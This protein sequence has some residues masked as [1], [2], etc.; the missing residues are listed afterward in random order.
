MRKKHEG[1]HQVTRGGL[2]GTALASG[3]AVL[4]GLASLAP[5]AALAA[6]DRCE[7]T[8]NEHLARMNVDPGDVRSVS[9]AA[10]IASQRGGSA[11]GY[12]VWIN[13]ESCRGA[14]VLRLDR[15]CRVRDAYSTGACSFPDL[16][17]Y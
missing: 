1:K 4:L 15:H 5:T 11:S 2:H 3:L 14:I 6:R 9:L 7:T 13:L 12:D 17:H 16:P 10:R 8:V